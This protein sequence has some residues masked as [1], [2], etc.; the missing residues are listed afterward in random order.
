MVSPCDSRAPG[1][2]S[3]H[4][5]VRAGTSRHTRFCGRDVS[6]SHPSPYPPDRPRGAPSAGTPAFP[7]A[8]QCHGRVGLVLVAPLPAG[9]GTRLSCKTAPELELVVRSFSQPFLETRGAADAVANP[10][11]NI[12]L[13]T[14]V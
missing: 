5:A 9:Q 6:S 4:R 3:A 11:G 7:L 2:G 8:S 10:A 14:V 1:S 12:R 13:F